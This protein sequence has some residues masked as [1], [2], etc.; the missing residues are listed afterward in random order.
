MTERTLRVLV[1][2]AGAA[3]LASWFLPVMD[4][5]W[6]CQAFRYSISGVWPYHGTR[7]SDAEDAIPLL[8]GAC[9]NFAFVAMIAML[10]RNRVTRPG[11]FFRVA[12]ACLLIDLYF[13]VQAARAEGLQALRELLIG[14]WAWLLAFVLVC[15]VGGF[16]AFSNR[17]TSKTPT[18]GTPA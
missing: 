4:D 5:A 16:S 17:R 10:L 8:L 9:T 18:A 13:P 2:T 15:V 12:L 11:L 1:W 3:W 6:G 7:P 14:Y